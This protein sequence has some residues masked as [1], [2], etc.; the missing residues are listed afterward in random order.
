MKFLNFG[1]LNLDYVYVLD[2]IVA[3]G[4]TISSTSLEVFPGGKG[5]N[6]SVSLSRA[7]AEVY[8][9]GMIGADGDLLLHTCADNGVHTD[10]IQT[11][12][13]RSGHAIIQLSS[14]GENSIVL[15]G[16]ANQMNSEEYIDEVLSHFEAGDILLLQNEINLLD[17]II[18]KAAEKGLIIALNPSPFNEKIEQ[19]D[20]NKVDIFFINEVEGKQITGETKSEQILEKMSQK[21]PK[22]KIVLTLGKYGVTFY[23]NGQIH[24]HGIYQVPRVDTTAAGD[25]F[26]GY[27]LYLYAK[28]VGA[29]EA[30]RKASIAS[31]I[32]VSRKGAA[33]SIPFMKE[34]EEAKLEM[35]SL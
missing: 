29:K 4:E 6:Q 33:P 23:E 5:L 8:H 1:S 19:C 11:V 3:P 24:S 21:Y 35:E 32:A 28:G 18:Q 25:T 34:V 17:S 30:L 12:S 22:A 20:L 26:T 13:E 14:S 31:S 9:A 2:H 15:F 7:G 10:Y 27:F 16:G